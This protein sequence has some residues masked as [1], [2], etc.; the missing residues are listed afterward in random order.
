[1]KQ[2]MGEKIAEY[3]YNYRYKETYIWHKIEEFYDEAKKI[4]FVLL[5]KETRKGEYFVKLPSSIWVTCPGYPPLSTDSALQN[6][7]GKKQT[8]FFAGLPTV[9]SQE[10]IKIF[11][12]F[13]SEKLKPFGIDYEKSS[14]ELKKRTLSRNISITGFLHF[15]KDILDEDFAPQILDIVCAAYGKVI[16][17]SPYECPVNEWRE[18]IIEKQAINEYYLFK[19]DGF[20]VPLSGQRAFF[21]MLMDER[22]LPD[23]EEN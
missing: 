10:H 1:M 19:K 12:N 18:R 17:S 22:E 13:L 6:L 15:K 5:K 11:D 14:K 20:D 4:R 7:P 16:Q 3:D 21:T 9:Q 2:L 8:L 23:R